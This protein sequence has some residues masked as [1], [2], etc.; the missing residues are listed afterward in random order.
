MLLTIPDIKKRVA[1]CYVIFPDLQAARIESKNGN[2]HII[3]EFVWEKKFPSNKNGITLKKVDLMLEVAH[4]H[5]LHDKSMFD[6]VFL[7]IQFIFIIYFFNGHEIEGHL[8]YS[9]SMADLI[10]LF[11]GQDK[12]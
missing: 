1:V 9:Y 5:I 11:Y 10:G 8:E 4:T 3:F 12:N 2:Q 6:L 7:N